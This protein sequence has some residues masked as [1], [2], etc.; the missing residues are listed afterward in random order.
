MAEARGSMKRVRLTGH[1]RLQCA[2][3]GATAEEV[4]Q[5]VREGMREPSKRGRLLCRF[6]FPFGRTWQGTW[7]AVKQVAPVIA[8]EADETVVVTV[9]TF[10]F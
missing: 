1:A 5:A 4:V 2:E 3:R 7:Y 9:Y 8:E 6:N 10:Y